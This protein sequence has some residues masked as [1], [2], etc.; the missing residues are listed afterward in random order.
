MLPYKAFVCFCLLLLS[1]RSVRAQH[2]EETSLGRVKVSCSL[3]EDGL[4]VY[5]VSFDGKPVI[6]PS[7]L[8]FVL[9]EDSLFYKGFILKG[10]DR[11]SV[12]NTWQPV[13]GETKDIRDH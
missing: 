10:V 3:E 9:N 1:C 6:L 5:T 8:G 2:T 7:R 13:W 11:K 12:D 4:P